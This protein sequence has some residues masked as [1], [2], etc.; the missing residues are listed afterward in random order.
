MS[1]SLRL[2]LIPL[3]IRVVT[4][5]TGIIESNLHYNEPKK[6]LPPSSYYK[7]VEGWI[8]DRESGKNRPPG[9][10]AQEYATQFVTRCESGVKGKIYIGPLTPLFVYLRWWMPTFIWVSFDV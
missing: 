6:H 3:K 8:A 10:P 1:E 9:M 2:E 5:I 4:V 7:S